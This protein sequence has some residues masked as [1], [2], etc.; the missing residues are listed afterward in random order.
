MPKVSIIVPVYNAEKTLARCLDSL[1]S[2]TCKDIEILLINDG[3]SD[4]SEDICREYEEGFP[5][6]RVITQKNSG[7]ATARNNGIDHALGEYISFVDADDYVE[8]EYITT[9]LDA[10]EKN[11]ADMV[12]C[13]YYEES[14]TSSKAHTFK[15]KEGLYEGEAAKEIAASLISDVSE[16]RIPPYSWVRM[17]RKDIFNNPRIRYTDGMVRSEDYYLYTKLHFR[18]QKVYLLSETPLYHYIENTTSVTH[19][20][21]KNYWKSVKEIYEGLMEKLPSEGVIQ[22]SLDIMLLQRSM[23]ALNNASRAEEEQA[24]KSEV[25]EIVKDDNLKKAVRNFTFREGMSHFGPYYALMR[26]G[27]HKVVCSRYAAKRK[28]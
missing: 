8:P 20:Y 5:Y 23:I 2:Q 17:V 16:H 11:C 19:S 26:L 13:A 7:P 14:E 4:G 15:Y 28:K 22:K 24:F 12:I 27:L 3:S 1:V 9:M 10:A 18:V 6:V 25:M 21:V